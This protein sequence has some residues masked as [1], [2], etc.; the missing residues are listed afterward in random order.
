MKLRLMT[1]F[2][3]STLIVG[4]FGEKIAQEL[5]ITNDSS[6]DAKT[7]Y[8]LG[9]QYAKGLSDLNLDK[10]NQALFIKGIQ[11]HFSNKIQLNNNDIQVYAK[12]A[13]NTRQ[14]NRS[15]QTIDQ[16]EIGKKA[17]KQMIQA[18]PEIII[19]DSGLAYQIIEMGKVIPN[20]KSSAFIGLNYESSHLDGK[21][22]ESTLNGN[23][24]QLPLR[25]IFKAWQEAFKIVG[26]GG[27][28]MIIS[29]PEL[30]YGNNGALPYVEPGEYLKF[31]L[32]F[33]D[34]SEAKPTDN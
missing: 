16:K 31:N 10:N 27:K 23:P 20:P 1:I 24:R 14:E 28:V 29:P 22:Y 3:V 18:N 12:K 6:D 7:A 5:K 32:N 30:T 26:T 19:S 33:S 8:S 11:D 2:T 34:Y 25:G 15:K 4:C 21:V 9:V 13:D 17:L